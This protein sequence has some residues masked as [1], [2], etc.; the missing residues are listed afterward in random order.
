MEMNINQHE[1][2]LWT[3]LEDNNIRDFWDRKHCFWSMI[4]NSTG[5]LDLNQDLWQECHLH[6]PT[7]WCTKPPMYRELNHQFIHE[8][9]KEVWL[10]VYM[11]RV[12]P[13]DEMVAMSR[14]TLWESAFW[15]CPPPMDFTHYNAWCEHYHELKCMQIM[16]YKRARFLH[17]LLNSGREIMPTR[18]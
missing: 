2:L 16:R 10:C 4:G 3:N 1:H 12:K 17:L 9:V 18:R 6:L 14:P 13:Q 11:C 7:H 5:D 8:L 15:E